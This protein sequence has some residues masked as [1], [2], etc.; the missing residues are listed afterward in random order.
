MPLLPL[1]FHFQLVIFPYPLNKFS[2]PG[3]YL[4][5]AVLILLEFLQIIEDFNSIAHSAHLIQ[6]IAF[7]LDEGN[8]AT[9]KL[10]DVLMIVEEILEVNLL[11]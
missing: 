4:F 9:D 10:Y 11:I 6:L 8:L 5:P 3:E 7:S 2:F 1:G